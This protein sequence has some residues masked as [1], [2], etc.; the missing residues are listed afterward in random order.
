LTEAPKRRIDQKVAAQEYRAGASIREIAKKNDVGYGTAQRA[1]LDEGVEMRGM[2][3]VPQPDLDW[4]AMADDYRAGA[5]VTEVARKHDTSY[6]V[7]YR[8][9][10]RQ[11]VEM[12][13]P[14][15]RSTSRA[16]HGQ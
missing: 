14:G 7:T 11:G 8:A 16:Q 3:G 4:E 10:A 2:G 9:L 1:L 6:G 12:R 13:P 5:T 15:T